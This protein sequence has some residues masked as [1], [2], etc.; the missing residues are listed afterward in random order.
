MFESAVSA[1]NNLLERH[2]WAQQL[3]GI[4]PLSALIDF[5]EVPQKVHVFELTGAVP[6]WSWP[7]TPAGS[8]LLLSDKYKQKICCLDR[9]GS[10]AASIALDGRYGDQY[11]VINPETVRFCLTSQKPHVIK[12][13]HEN[14]SGHDLRV[15][16]IEVVHVSRLKGR[17]ERRPST[18]WFGRLFL[19]LWWMSSAKHLVVSTIGW[20]MMIGMIIMSGIL[21]C[22]LSLAFLCAVSATGFVTFSLYGRTPRRLLVESTSNYNRVVVVAEHMNT[23]DWTVFYG[24]STIVNS[25][26][27]RPLEPLGPQM[28]PATSSLLRM[29][30]RILILGQWATA[31]GATA[32]QDWNAYF[33]TF[34]VA[35][36]ITTHSMLIPVSME[37][38]DWMKSVASIQMDRY[39][40]QVSSRRALLNTII[41][42]NPDTFAW[43]QTEKNDDRT[44]LD[45]GAT[46][47]VDS[48][49][50]PGPS[51]FTWE[52]AT[53]RAMKEAAEKYSIDELASS[54]WQD[55]EG[56]VL[57]PEWNNDFPSERKNYWKPFI[58][59]G[60]YMAA[61]I[62]KE[63]N[64]SGRK[65]GSESV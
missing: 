29:A 59:E 36:C 41:A 31:I 48:V 10:S 14:M 26:L 23:I 5:V 37:A 58:L 21:E 56:D 11:L 35:F 25:L 42:L 33:I 32:L 50:A 16:N 63:A 60:I 40:V 55:K 28:P 62:Q 6:L 3:A 4:L 52:E 1:L 19:D 54:K 65:I 49:L 57:S 9:Y 17:P 15:Q 47:W 53:R 61:K 64:L 51:R 22:Y 45:K 44:K 27:N 12:N 43:S 46:R 30:L 2:L 7:V 38:K 13:L 18:S 34:W 39:Q 20:I 8:R 24:E